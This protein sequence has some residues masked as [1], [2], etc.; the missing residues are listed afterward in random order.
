MSGEWISDAIDCYSKRSVTF[1]RIGDTDVASLPD[2]AAQP[3]QVVSAGQGLHGAYHS[4][5]KFASGGSPPDQ[6]YRVDTACLRTGDRCISRLVLTDGSGGILY[7]FRQRRLDANPRGRL[8]V[9]GWSHRAPQDQ[10]RI[11]RA[12]PTPRPDRATRRTWL[13][14]DNRQFLQRRGFPT[15]LNRTGN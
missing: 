15:G 14:R 13:Q 6:D 1:T 2:P 7:I 5:V 9:R 8:H 10:H 3:A 12:Q 4:T 11:P